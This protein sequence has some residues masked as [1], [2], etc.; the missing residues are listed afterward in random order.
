MLF[1]LLS[2]VVMYLIK[3]ELLNRGC[4]GLFVYNMPDY[5]KI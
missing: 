5:S 1:F 2:F 3:K 4:V